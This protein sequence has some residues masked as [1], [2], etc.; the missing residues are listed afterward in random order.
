M[1]PRQMSLALEGDDGEPFPLVYLAC[2]LTGINDRERQLLD[3]WCTI[4][5]Q[6]VIDCAEGSTDRWDVSI[7]VPFAW[8]APWNDTRSEE[9]VYR[10]NR[11][12]VGSCAALI[13]L[14]VDGG[15]LGGGQEF[16]WVTPLR[17]PILLLHPKDEAPSRQA[18]GTPADVA[19]VGF[20]G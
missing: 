10:L 12:K 14:C 2:R 4:I 1:R 11:M 18:I 5:E 6:A 8:S 9:D 7:H 15:G 3:S 19:V 20:D 16:A 17:M 13:I